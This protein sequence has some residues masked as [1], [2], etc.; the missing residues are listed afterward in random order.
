M[1]YLTQS[2]IAQI[3][4]MP[5][6]I[7]LMRSAFRQLSNGQAQVPV[8]EHLQLRD[9]Q[10]EAF[11]MPVYL[12][13]QH[14]IGQKIVGLNPENPKLGQPFVQAMILVMDAQTG[15]VEGLM[16]GTWITALRTGAGSGLATELLALPEAKTLAVFGT[17][18][19]AQTQVAAVCAVRPMQKL[20]VYY[21]NPVQAKAF[22]EVMKKRHAL[23][24]ELCQDKKSLSK[25]EVICTATTSF[26]PLFSL[27]HLHPSVHINA[28]GAYRPD[29]AE[30][31]PAVVAQ[32]L[33][34]I[35]QKAASLR[36]AGD[37]IQAQ[38]AKQT[39]ADNWVELGQMVNGKHPGRTEEEQITFFKSVGNAAQDLVVAAFVLAEAKKQGLGQQLAN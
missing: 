12:P 29:M 3:V 38:I 32:S 4:D 36:E 31:P 7:D 33:V 19:Q 13:E 30:V 24:V 23:E 10:T 9:S 35:D 17:G 37:L 22:A 18:V 2:E 21:R 16:E 8:R 26:T 27:P 39:D 25:A 11:F 20:L 34:V 14:Y 6:A 28:V 15:K 1:L 5:R